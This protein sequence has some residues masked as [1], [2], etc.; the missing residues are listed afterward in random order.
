MDEKVCDS[1]AIKISRCPMESGIT[2]IEENA[3]KHFFG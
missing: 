1:E 3:L 2:E